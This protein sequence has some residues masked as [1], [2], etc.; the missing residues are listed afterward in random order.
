MTEVESSVYPSLHYTHVYRE[1]PKQ[2]AGI[3]HFF[4]IYFYENI[5]TVDTYY[6]S[7][8]CTKWW[9]TIY[10]HYKLITMISLGIICHHT[11]IEMLL[12]L[13]PY[14]VCYIP[15]TYYIYIWS[16]YFLIPFT[17]FIHPFTSSSLRTT[18]SSLYLWICF[19]FICLF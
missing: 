18:V 7:F 19:C 17:Y 15:V 8:R 9:L 6:I 5:L 4:Y 1:S 16:L 3:I 14:A 2:C 10:M 11:V 13:L 12:T